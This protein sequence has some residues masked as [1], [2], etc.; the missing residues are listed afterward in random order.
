MLSHIAHPTDDADHCDTGY[1]LLICVTISKPMV[2]PIVLLRDLK[3]AV[4]GT[5]NQQ[6]TEH[7]AYRWQKLI[8]KFPSTNIARDER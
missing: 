8:D 1:K 4:C 3:C 7:L 5:I 2:R 6:S